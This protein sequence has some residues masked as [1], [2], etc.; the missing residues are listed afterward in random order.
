MSHRW[1]RRLL[2]LASLGVSVALPADACE[3]PYAEP[4]CQAYW[5]ASVVFVGT[6]RKIADTET[7]R[8][9]TFNV[10]QAERGVTTPTID[11]NA[12][13]VS[14][15]C[16]SIFEVGQ[17]YVVYA[18]REPGKTPFIGSCG[19]TRHVRDA[20]EDLA[21]FREMKGPSSGAHIVGSV[22]HREPDLS[23]SGPRDVG[24]LAGFP[25]HLQGPATRRTMSTDADGR[26]DFGGLRPG[27]Y[28]LSVETPAGMLFEPQMF[29]VY[30]RPAAGTFTVTLRAARGC[31]AFNLVA[32]ETGG[33]RGVLTDHR[34]T[35]LDG[36][37]VFVV[38]AGSAGSSEAMRER[39][40]TDQNGRFEFTPLPR[41]EYVV[42]V[43]LDERREPTMLD[44]R[45]YYNGTRV[46]GEARVVTID[47]PS[48]VDI[49]KF[50]LPAEPVERTFTGVVSWSDGA[51]AA[52]A[53]LILHG[54]VGQ[55][56]A[57]DSSGSFS[58]TLPY[59]A[60]FTLR[61]TG[62]RRLGGRVGESSAT[63]EIDRYDRDRRIELVLR[64][65]E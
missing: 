62:S 17:R 25:I 37:L 10:E 13:P 63:T 3:C 57:L 18:Y 65:P 60:K 11:V 54:A 9:L 14:P 47:G 29:G 59:G 56:V 35:P 52:D 55:R 39:I 24:P 27:E 22:R 7:A 34:G 28:T 45:S 50:Q 41:G 64:V 6:V 48:I 21:Y 49:G 4:P 43:G 8:R 19:R 23:A 36:E 30:S 16:K 26:Y 5:E 42:A 31:I 44:R 20:S 53:V 15:F 1:L 12:S 61:A 38:A 33:I 32:R 2:A 46:A 58:I 51:P 40:R